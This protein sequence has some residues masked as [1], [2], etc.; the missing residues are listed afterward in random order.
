MDCAAKDV[1]LGTHQ[2]TPGKLK[3]FF[4]YGSLQARLILIRWLHARR[5]LEKVVP[6]S[7]VHPRRNRLAAQGELMNWSKS[8]AQAS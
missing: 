7:M 1:V 3:F 5:R 8:L 4:G 6:I 2:K